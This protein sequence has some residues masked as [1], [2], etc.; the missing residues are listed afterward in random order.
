MHALPLKRYPTFFD[1]RICSRLSILAGGIDFDA[2]RRAEITRDMHKMKTTTIFLSL[3]FLL[4]AIVACSNDQV[5]HD[6]A[7]T[8]DNEK[9]HMYLLDR[10]GEKSK[11]SNDAVSNPKWSPNLRSVAYLANAEDGKGQLKVWHRDTD[12]AE[13]VADA[14]G[15]VEDFFWSPDSRM[16]AYQ[17]NS[18]DDTRSEVFVHDFENERTIPLVSELAGNVELGNWS[19]DNQWIVMCLNVD[20]SPGLYKRSVHGVD[21][22]QLTDYEDSRPRFSSDGKRVAFARKH[23]DGSTDIYTL[24]VDTGNGPSVAKALTDEDGDETHFEWAPNGRN[25]IYVSERD[26]N[27]EIYSVDTSEKTT[28]RMTQNRVNDAD[29]KWSLNGEQVLFRSVNDGKYLLFAMDFNSGSQVRIL[30][31][32]SDILQADW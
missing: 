12:N 8:L 4:I 29:P 14:P 13:R 17:A 10:A 19:G 9:N 30:N 15:N 5:S 27:A 16:I 7:Y 28:R 3:V 6:V 26:G 2:R 25:I 31:E 24:D 32:D 21:E 11:V 20:G 23:S 22:V 18:A 1:N